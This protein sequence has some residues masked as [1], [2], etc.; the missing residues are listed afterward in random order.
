MPEKEEKEE[1]TF[2]ESPYNAFFKENES[3][4]H[5]PRAVFIDTEPSVMDDLRTGPFQELFHPDQLIS[6]K[7]DAANNYAR[8]HNNVGPLFLDVTMD[9]IRRQA[10]MCE[11]MQG[12]L[13]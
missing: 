4:K 11:G 7:E 10:D 13:T 12:L 2:K 1:G 6:G 5:V 3:G 9:R 8:G